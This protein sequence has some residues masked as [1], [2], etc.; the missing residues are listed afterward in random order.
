MDCD[1]NRNKSNKNV[2]ETLMKILK[3]ALIIN[4]QVLTQQRSATNNRQASS[5]KTRQ[6]H[7]YMEL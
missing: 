1:V 7:L 3:Q 5:Q 2:R 4:Q 6:I